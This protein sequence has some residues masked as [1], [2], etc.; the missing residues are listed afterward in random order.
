MAIQMNIGEAKTRLSELVAASLR[1]EEVILARAGKPVLRFEALEEAKAA[2]RARIVAERSAKIKA[3]F[4]SKKDRLGPNAG[5]LFL[6]DTYTDE[7]L[8]SF[9]TGFGGD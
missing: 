7:E 9:S 3:Y 1:G 2:D 4:G 8:D 5:D 6:G